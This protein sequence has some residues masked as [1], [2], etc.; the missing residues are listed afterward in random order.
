MRHG[1]FDE[2]FKD[3]DFS[4]ENARNHVRKI[5][6]KNAENLVALQISS[7]DAETEVMKVLPQLQRFAK[8]YTNLDP[9][10]GPRNHAWPTLELSG[11]QRTQVQFLAT[12]A[13]AV[14]EPAISHELGLRGSVDMVVEASTA[15]STLQ[16]VTRDSALMSVELKT[17]HNQATH[18]AHTAQLALYIIMLQARFGRKRTFSASATA[19]R[20]DGVLLYMNNEAIKAVHVV[21]HISEIKSLIENRN[22]IAIETLRAARP[23]GILL[24]YQN[25][26]D[27]SNNAL[28]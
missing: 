27:G 2:T 1:L 10:P 11:M 21:P 14:E 6:R 19:P 20:G 17:G 4:A 16:G 23:R 18:H 22:T 9:S 7:Q 15:S 12:K 3:K 13:D 26:Q 5:V 24:S 25:E 8:Q 28:K